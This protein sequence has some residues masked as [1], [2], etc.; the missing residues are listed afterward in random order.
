[1]SNIGIFYG[2]ANDNDPVYRKDASQVELIEAVA[3]AALQHDS[4]IIEVIPRSR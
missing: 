3:D 2:S 1:M 4:S